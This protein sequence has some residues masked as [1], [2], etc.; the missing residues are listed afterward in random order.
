MEQLFFLSEEEVL[1]IQENYGTPI[2]VYD[3]QSMF[4]SAQEV[5]SFPHA[6]GFTARFAMK[7]LPTRKILQKFHKWGLHIDASSEYEAERALRAGI[8]P[9]HIQITAQ[10]LPI[11][12][13]MF[14]EKG[15]LFNACSLQQLKIYGE[16]FPGTEVSVRIN[17]GLG[18]GSSNRTNVGGPSSSF[19]IWHEYL[20]KVYEVANKYNLKITGLHTHIG[21]GSD[22]EVWVHCAHLAL[23]TASKMPDVTRLSLGGGYKV[24][25]MADEKTANLQEIGKRILPSFYE[26][27]KKYGRKLHLEI[28]PGTYLVALAGS[29]ICSVIDVVD[30]GPSGY[31]FIKV[32]SGMTENVRP[33]MYGALHPLVL[34]SKHNNASQGEYPYIVSGHCCESGDIFTPQRGDPESLEPRMLKEATIGDALVVEGAGAY[35]SSQSCKNYNSFPECGEILRKGPFDYEWIRKFQTLEQMIQNEL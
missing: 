13:K 34:V 6:F 21:S 29:L 2:F 33:S 14:V 24:A 35:C 15:V 16:M 12:L 26:F 31:R 7:A 10:Q 23:D 27:E 25:R 5:L 9:Q 19:G 1:H 18:S 30:T 3:E 8:P 17:P 32:D 11:N 22:P 28:E 20:D 4:K